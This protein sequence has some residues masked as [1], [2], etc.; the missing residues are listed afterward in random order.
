MSLLR[1]ICTPSAYKY[2]DRINRVKASKIT[3]KFFIISP[4]YFPTKTATF[5]LDA[6]LP[7]ALTALV[8]FPAEIDSPG[9]RRTMVAETV[10]VPEKFKYTIPVASLFW[11]K[12]SCPEERAVTIS[13]AVPVTV[14]VVCV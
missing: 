12:M 2:P 1:V 14:T 13:A 9:F 5:A 4:N 11:M 6:I 7:I 10:A 3:F 8:V